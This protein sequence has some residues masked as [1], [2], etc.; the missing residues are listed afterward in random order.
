[1]MAVPRDVSWANPLDNFGNPKPSLIVKLIA[2][3]NAFGEQGYRA[4]M[5]DKRR[6]RLA[7]KSGNKIGG[8]VYFISRGKGMWYG[9]QQHLAAGIWAK[10]GTH[11]VDIAPVFLFVKKGSYRQVIDLSS[12]GESTV[13]RHWK[14]E[15]DRELVTAIRNSK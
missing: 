11:G 1:M 5:T 8:V 3:F 4:N 7:K 10:R 15:F 6:E 9:R 14:P 12:I 13:I 2:Y